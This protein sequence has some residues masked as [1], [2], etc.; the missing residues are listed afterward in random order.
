ME[1]NSYSEQLRINSDG[2]IPKVGNRSS[3]NLHLPIMSATTATRTAIRTTTIRPSSLS[4]S[5]ARSIRRTR[6][7]H[8][9]HQ[10]SSIPPKPSFNRRYYLLAIPLAFLPFTLFGS[11]KKPLDPYTY[12]DHPVGS[13]SKLTPH[14]ARIRIPL[15]PANAALFAKSENGGTVTIEHVMIK[16]PDLQIER[17]Y[18]PVNDV[19]GDGEVDIVVKRVQGG[20]VGR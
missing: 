5:L 8:R 6:L 9:R 17:P 7:P 4:E 12:S 16:N 20:E 14:H 15:S 19:R 13:T 18:T 10:S 11:S 2:S 1:V 3:V